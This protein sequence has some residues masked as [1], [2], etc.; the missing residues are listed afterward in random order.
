[1]GAVGGFG[2][3]SVGLFIS[4]DPRVARDPAS[5]DVV[6][7][8]GE[9]EEETGGEDGV[10]VRDA[11]PK[12]RKSVPESSAVEVDVDLEGEFRGVFL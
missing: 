1:M 11:P 9:G 3:D 2:G 12:P 8:G 10:G 5:A 6:A 4:V 7:E